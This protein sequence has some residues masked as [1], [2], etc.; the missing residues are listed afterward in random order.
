MRLA[1]AVSVGAAV[2]AVG[3]SLVVGGLAGNLLELC[4]KVVNLLSA[5]IFVLFYLALFVPRA[6]AAA[7][8]AATVAGVAAAVAVA[9]GW[10][11][12]WF[13]WSPPAALVVGVAV[14]T[15]VGYLPLISP[16]PPSTRP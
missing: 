15:A 8:V 6:S 9:F 12:R 1:R 11:G 2:A 10:G 7:A 5:P 14:G 16:R 4:F 3:L 13:L